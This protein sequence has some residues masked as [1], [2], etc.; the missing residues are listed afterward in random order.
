M[1]W[2]ETLTA[3]ATTTIAVVMVVWSIGLLLL[4]AELRRLT[5]TG[6]RVIT[7]LDRD[8]R[9]VLDSVRSVSKDAEHL[10]TTVRSEVDGFAGTSRNLRAQ[11]EFA[12]NSVEDRLRNLE[13]LLD[14]VQDEVEDTALDFAAALRTTRRGSGLIRRM[15]RAFLRS[16]R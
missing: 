4:F 13:A 15:R 9:P 1:T 10:V 5:S 16:G 11:V 2:A 12:A 6:T 14:V 8:V 3:I 7:S